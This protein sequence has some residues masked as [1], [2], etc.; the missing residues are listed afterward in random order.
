MSQLFGILLMLAGMY[1]LGQNIMFSTFYSPYFWRNLPAV[2]S[3]LAIMGGVT[4]L[5][6][7]RRQTGS[8]G[9]ILLIFGIVLVFL[10]GGVMLKPTNLWNFMIAF[11][12]LI[13]GFKLLTEGRL[14][15]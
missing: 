7:F 2:G 8:F 12:A 3:V 15:F 6:F 10:S 5:L 14:R 11:A 4:S 1:F 13:S 9:W